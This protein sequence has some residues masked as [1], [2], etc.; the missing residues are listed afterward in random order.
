MIVQ[1]RWKI[2][3]MRAGEP[4]NYAKVFC[5]SADKGEKIRTCYLA[6]SKPLIL[7]HEVREEIVWST[8]LN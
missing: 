7:Q 6:V 2:L 1:S 8:A 4:L 5:F 3:E